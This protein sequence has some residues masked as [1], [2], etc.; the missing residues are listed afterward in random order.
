MDGIREN[1]LDEKV[2]PTNDFKV[3]AL[4]EQGKSC[5]I[6]F[7]SFSGSEPQENEVKEFLVDGTIIKRVYLNGQW[8]D[9]GIE[10][11]M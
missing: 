5:M 3:R 1:K 6:P 9:T 8:E 11:D 10:Y 2:N 4:D 7:S